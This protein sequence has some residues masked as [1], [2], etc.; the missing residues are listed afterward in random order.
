MISVEDITGLVHSIVS[1]TASPIP[2]FL[3]ITALVRIMLSQGFLN[4]KHG[5]EEPTKKQIEYVRDL[6]R[7]HPE[8]FEVKRI[9]KKWY[10]RLKG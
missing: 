6:L 5:E 9:G 4:E 1:D 3:T 7:N 8:S 2:G 10:L